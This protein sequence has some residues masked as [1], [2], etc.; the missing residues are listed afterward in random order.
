[1]AF[2]TGLHPTTRLCIQALEAHLK[3]GCSVLDVGTGSGVLA[4]AA[5]KLGASSVLA[6]DND[7]V[8][9]RVAGENATLNGVA[10]QVTV[11]RGS[12]PGDAV[13][14]WGPVLARA[15]DVLPLLES[16]QFDLV[17]INILA[18]VVIGLARALS[19]RLAPRGRLI[20]A[21]LIENQEGEV[22][23]T[24]QSEELQIAERTQEQDWVCLV[25]H[26]A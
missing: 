9:V 22:V 12:L 24:L 3:P 16:G 15:E 4:I 20:V 8:A 17:V 13:E 18:K 10:D 14:R 19:A 25:A 6:L 23:R 7:P 1:M 2:G 11:Q 26:K 21:G 5:A